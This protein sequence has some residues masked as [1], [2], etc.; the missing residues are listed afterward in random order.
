MSSKPTHRSLTQWF[1]HLGTESMG[2]PGQMAQV[3]LRNSHKCQFA[4][5][6]SGF[7][8]SQVSEEVSLESPAFRNR[9][10]LCTSEKKEETGENWGGLPVSH[11]DSPGL[12][13]SLGLAPRNLTESQLD[14]V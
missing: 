12:T 5:E 9:T 11:S 6:L 8:A 10:E 13:R 3:R 2:V 14:P 1:V 7:R 4:H